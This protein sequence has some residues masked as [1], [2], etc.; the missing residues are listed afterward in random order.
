MV[1]HKTMLLRESEKRFRFSGSNAALREFLRTY[2]ECHAAGFDIEL[3]YAGSEEVNI[4]LDPA[5]AVL[6]RRR[7]GETFEVRIVSE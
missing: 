5:Y 4:S 1:I 3:P 2:Q 6:V 7:S